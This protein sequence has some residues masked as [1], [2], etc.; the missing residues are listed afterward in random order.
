[1]QLDDSLAMTALELTQVMT[2]DASVPAA[3]RLL[4]ARASSLAGVS[5][6]ALSVISEGRVKFL[7]GDN[8]SL[9]DLEWAQEEFQRGPCVAAWHSGEPVI[10][11][12]VTDRSDEWPA[13]ASAARRLRVATAASLPIARDGHVIGVLDVYEQA[14]R[15]LDPDTLDALE[16]LCHL[17][18]AVIVETAE[19]RRERGGPPPTSLERH[20]LVERAK[21]SIAAEHGV[22][23][24]DAGEML[25][26]HADVT[27]L[28][29]HEVATAVLYRDLDVQPGRDSGDGNSGLWAPDLADGKV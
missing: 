17:G 26:R 24:A 5:G 18:I 3:L 9:A 19:D 14:A 21:A 11:D 6:T 27:G 25:Q 22:D 2:A 23:P 12:P 1:M 15:P 29:L 28:P 20:V 7:C 16:A 10:L 13:W 4:C 8:P